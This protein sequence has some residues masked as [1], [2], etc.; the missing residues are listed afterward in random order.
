MTCFG[1]CIRDN[2]ELQIV[3]FHFCLSDPLTLFS[4]NI[5]GF[6]QDVIRACKSKDL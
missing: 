3:I 5:N 4:L 1:R 2:I 6:N